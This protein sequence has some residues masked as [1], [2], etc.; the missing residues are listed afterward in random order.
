MTHGVYSENSLNLRRCLCNDFKLV[1]RGQVPVTDMHDFA[2]AA[3]DGFRLGLG[4][5]EA[6]DGSSSSAIQR[7]LE[8]EAESVSAATAR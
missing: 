3:A 6:P 4:S 8:R 7:P 1:E 2:T 5:L